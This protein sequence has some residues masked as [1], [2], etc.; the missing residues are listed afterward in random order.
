MADI[1]TELTIKVST[2]SLKE[3]LLQPKSNVIQKLSIFVTPII[4][5]Y[6]Y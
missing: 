1:E 5:A 6:D 3:T 2:F 4:T